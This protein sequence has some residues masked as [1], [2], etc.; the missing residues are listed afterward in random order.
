MSDLFYNE[1]LVDHSLHPQFFCELDNYDDKITL[2]NPSCGDKLTIYIKYI[3]GRVT[4]A[5]FTGVGCAI[6]KASADIMC[7]EIIGKTADEIITLKDDWKQIPALQ[8]VQKMPARI[9]CASL[10]WQA[11]E[12]VAKKVQKRP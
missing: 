7:G 12:E 11:L 10:S 6:S 4:N 3:E 8:D 2:S 5:S 1:E 9:K